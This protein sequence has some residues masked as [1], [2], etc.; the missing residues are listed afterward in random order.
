MLVGLS[1]KE[2]LLTTVCAALML[3]LM[4]LLIWINSLFMFLLAFFPAAFIGYLVM[5]VHYPVIQK[6]VINPYYEDTGEQNPEADDATAD[7]GERLFTDRG[8]S[9]EPVKQESAKKGK[10]IS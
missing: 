4:V 10:T 9:E 8:G 3:G 5:F 6:Y 2:C 1:L 7:D